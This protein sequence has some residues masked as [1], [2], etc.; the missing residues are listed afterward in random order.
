VAAEVGENLWVPI[1][2]FF[3]S[4]RCSSFFFFPSP[5]GCN[6]FWDFLIFWTIANNLRVVEQLKKKKLGKRAGKHCVL[7][8]PS[9]K[10]R[11]RRPP[12]W[13][14][15]KALPHL[16]YIYCCPTSSRLYN[17]AI[18][19]GG[20]QNHF[21]LN[22]KWFFFYCS[23]KERRKK[24]VIWGE[25]QDIYQRG[26]RMFSYNREQSR[27]CSRETPTWFFLLLL[28]RYCGETILLLFFRN[29]SLIW[30]HDHID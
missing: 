1:L 14:I 6:L 18:V 13:K 11:G 8:W 5:N 7:H 30:Y 4:C 20:K 24:G 16:H 23:W 26:N 25:D 9:F 12:S 2:P 3:S 19:E 29:S 15:K 22:P 27:T 21:G 28:E 10:S 17:L